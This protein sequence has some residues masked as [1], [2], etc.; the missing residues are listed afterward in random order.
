MGWLAMLATPESLL[1]PSV[2][3][4]ASGTA[5]WGTVVPLPSWRS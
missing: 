4:T 2:P 3:M 5:L 1:F